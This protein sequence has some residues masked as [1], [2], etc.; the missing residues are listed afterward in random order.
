MTRNET[1]RRWLASAGLVITLAA[2]AAYVALNIATIRAGGATL[3]AF[4]LNGLVLGV[5]Y[6]IVGWIVASRRSDNPM[7]WLFL[8]I[9]LSQT[10]VAFAS[11]ASSYGLVLV[12]GSIPLADIWSWVSAWAW[13]PG[14]TMF[15]TFSLLLFPDG[16]LPSRRW[17]PV[18]WLSVVMLFLLAV[19][20]AVLAWPLRGIALMN[21]A[22]PDIPLAIIGAL[23]IPVLA[24]ASV[25]SIVIRFRHSTGP[26]RQ[27]LRWF[28]YA[29]IPEIAYVI[30]V[31]FNTLPPAIMLLGAIFIVP[32]LP[33]A[34]G[35]AILRY[36][37][38]DLDRIV[39]RTIAYAVVTGFLAAT[40]G[41][42]ILL[43]QAVLAPFT[44]GQ[45]VAVAASTLAVAAL[46]QPV[47]RRVRRAVDRRFDRAR[48]DAERTAAAFAERLRDEA[49]MSTVAT[50]L[51]GTIETALAPASIG[52]WLRGREAGR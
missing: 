41:A 23:M 33:I 31:G 17:R 7:G 10:V 51:T 1:T 18:A 24:L 49:D 32:L 4:T 39:S 15:V 37:L 35:I 28:T 50:D 25:G 36:R 6:G 26:E 52:I 38:F 47:M 12:P 40:F 3:D 34:I 20:N 44:Q 27:Q 2:V 45:T 9:A 16:H 11:I 22:P 13:A 21:A 8:V 19:P 48:Y 29:A 5:M 46:F 42:S 30:A 43:L 14:F